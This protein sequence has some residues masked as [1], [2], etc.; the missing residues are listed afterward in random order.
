MNLIGRLKGRDSGNGAPR[1]NT[2]ADING[3]LSDLELERTELQARLEGGAEKRRQLILQEMVDDV[4]AHD[5]ETRKVGI[6]LEIIREVDQALRVE[7]K[8]LKEA[9]LLDRVAFHQAQIRAAFEHQARALKEAAAANEA[10][11]AAYRAS[12]EVGTTHAS[13]MTPTYFGAFCRVDAVAHW[14]AETKKVLASV[15]ASWKRR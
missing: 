2:A 13:A 8:R 4:A 11:I 15:E 5:V 14:S 3:A 9:R 1:Q 10:A 7:L 12:G 6:R